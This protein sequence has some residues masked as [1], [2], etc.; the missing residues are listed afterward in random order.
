MPDGVTPILKY[1]TKLNQGRNFWGFSTKQTW[2]ERDVFAT[3]YNGQSPGLR[4]MLEVKVIT[5]NKAAVEALQRRFVAYDQFPS[6]SVQ[7][8]DNAL[9]AAQFGIDYWINVENFIAP[10]IQNESI[11]RI[12]QAIPLNQET[13]RSIVRPRDVE[14]KQKRIDA[15]IRK[16][17]NEQEPDDEAIISTI[18][19]MSNGQVASV[20]NGL[21]KHTDEDDEGDIGLIFGI[22]IGSV[23]LFILSVCAC[24]MPRMNAKKAPEVRG[25]G[26]SKGPGGRPAPRGNSSKQNLNVRNNILID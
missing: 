5:Y 21:N 17:R 2:G 11:I 15:Y 25:F 16:I 24:T 7:Y 6:N 23:T 18:D 13:I 10:N 14:D 26:N 4:T 12:P 1:E 8:Y 19:G 3:T 9:A 22:I 20:V